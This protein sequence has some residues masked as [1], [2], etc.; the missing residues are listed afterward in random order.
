MP[1]IFTL[2]LVHQVRRFAVGKGGDGISKASVGAGEQLG[3]DMDGTGLAA[4]TVA[5]EGFLIIY[6][7]KAKKKSNKTMI[8]L[9]NYI[10]LRNVDSLELFLLIQYFPV[11]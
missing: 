5:G 9:Q 8:S 7:S 10:L 6:E 1:Y 4:G 11:S 3:G 2:K